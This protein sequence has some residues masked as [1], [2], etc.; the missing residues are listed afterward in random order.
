MILTFVFGYTTAIINVFKRKM[1]VM[2]VVYNY[3]TKKFYPLLIQGNFSTLK[4]AKS[5]TFQTAF[6]MAAT[7]NSVDFG[8]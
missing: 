1:V 4:K 7:G 3:K 8:G 2:V 6:N 5:I